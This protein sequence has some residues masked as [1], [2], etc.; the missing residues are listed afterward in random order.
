MARLPITGWPGRDRLSRAADG[1]VV[2]VAVALPWSTSATAILIVLW[3]MALL[4]TLEIGAVRREVLSWAGGLPVLLWLLAVAGLAWADVPWRERLGGLESFHR[5]LLIPILFAQFRRSERATSVAFAFLLS[6]TVL[7]VAS[8]AHAAL[9]DIVPWQ[10]GS[11]PGVPVKNYITQSEFFEVCGFALLGF[12]V[13]VWRAGHRSQALWLLLLAAMFFYD[14]L[15]VATGRTAL[16]ALPI[17]AVVLGF[18]YFAWRGVLVAVGVGAVLA[19]VAW[20]SSPYL[21]FRVEHALGE[22]DFYLASGMVTSSGIRLELWKKSIG[23]VEQAPIFG[24]GTGSINEMFRR[25][26]VGAATETAALAAENPH[27]QVFAVA[28]QLGLVGAALLIAMWIAHLALFL[29]PGPVAWVGLVTVLVQVVACMFNSHLFDFTEGWFYIFGVGAIG[30]FARREQSTTT[31]P[32]QMPGAAGAG[33]AGPGVV[34]RD[35]L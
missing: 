16:V 12:A 7:L 25:S 11:T 18:K 9:W 26:A 19:M 35:A 24:H 31:L 13:D 27:Q 20:T 6:E 14:I 17:V 2:A 29:G 32:Q 23:F 30:G 5:L 22:V 10:I 8:L 15:Y 1:L 21:R 4:P 3:L 28:I 34:A 33:A